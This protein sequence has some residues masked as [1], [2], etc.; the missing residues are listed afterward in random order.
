MIALLHWECLL[1]SETP[2]GNAP[3]IDPSLLASKGKSIFNK[4]Y[5]NGSY[6]SKKENI[7]KSANRV[8]EML[9]DNIIKP[10]IGNEYPLSEII[11]VHKALESRATKGSIVLKK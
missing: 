8:F 6:N 3:A 5:F 7:Q 9:K 11:E 4:A 1:Y 2:S 10:N